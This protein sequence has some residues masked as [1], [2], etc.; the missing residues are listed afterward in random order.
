MRSVGFCTGHLPG[1][2]APCLP[3]ELPG[4]RFTNEILVVHWW[5]LQPDGAGATKIRNA[6]F[7]ADASARQSDDALRLLHDFLGDLKL[8][9]EAE[10][11]LDVSCF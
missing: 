2:V 3:V 8:I 1:E 10:H 5:L 6:R 11:D 7:G 4:L 9:L